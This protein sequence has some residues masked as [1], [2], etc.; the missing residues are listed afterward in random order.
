MF[1]RLTRAVLEGT[2]RPA[3]GDVRIQDSEVPSLSARITSTGR[4]A[5][6]VY[7]RLNG[8]QRRPKVGEWPTMSIERARQVARDVV[9][10][11]QAGVDLS[12]RRSAARTAPTMADHLHAYL[13]EYARPYKAPSSAYNDMLA[14]NRHILPAMGRVRVPDVTKRD[15]QRLLARIATDAPVQANRV[16]ALLSK[17]FA[18]AEEWGVREQGTNPAA[19]YRKQPEPRRQMALDTKGIAR[20]ATALAEADQIDR[21]HALTADL[22]RLLMLT[23]ARRDEVRLARRGLLDADTRRLKVPD[24]KER[25]PNKALHLGPTAWAI[26]ARLSLATPTPARPRSTPTCWTTPGGRRWPPSTALWPP[27]LAAENG[28]R[29]EINYRR[30][31]YVVLYCPHWKGAVPQQRRTTR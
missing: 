17:A 12:E 30:I 20:L 31:S 18:L 5:F 9:S 23:G 27:P 3:K 16:G 11:A 15:V 2:P 8:Q 4:V 26:C 1:K 21:H 14:I 28:T 19:G 7:Y 13:T 24:N 25:N 22:V 29:W 10:D 6:Y